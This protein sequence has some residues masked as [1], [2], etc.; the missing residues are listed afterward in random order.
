MSVAYSTGAAGVIAAIALGSS[1]QDTAALLA[2]AAQVA[3]VL[4][5]S[6][7]NESEA[8]QVGIELA[9]RAGYD[10]A[11]AVT[12]WDKMAK[13][14]GQPPEFLSTHPSPEHRKE[15]LE[16]LGQQ[17]EPLY[18]AARSGKSD[19]PSFLA[20]EASADKAAAVPSQLAREQYAARVA[21]EA[22]TMTF[23]SVPFNQ[24]RTG[25]ATFDCRLQ[26]AF[27][28]NNKKGDWK[29]LHEQKNWRELALS[30]MNVG[31]LGDLSYFMLAEAAKG[32]GLNDAA[33]LYYQ[34][35]IQAGR[36]YGC[37]GGLSNTCEGYDVQKLASAAL[38]R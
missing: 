10:P 27:S 30:V 6:R 19:A 14:G 2:E 20:K 8:D 15:R 25:T 24:F 32:L 9:A 21:K 33:R 35:A 16:Q 29:K 28:Y 11:A 22:D 18:V 37:A 12:L 23:Q 38:S 13:L 34:R 36:E 7:E 31:Y 17:V 1:R 4:P 26:C 3:I 5:N